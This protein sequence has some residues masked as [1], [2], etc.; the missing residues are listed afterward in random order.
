MT[1]W[2]ISFAGKS[3]KDFEDLDK[4]IKSRIRNVILEL[5]ELENPQT[6][7]KSKSLKYENHDEFSVRVGKHRFIYSL[8]DN[9]HFIVIK[10]IGKREK[11]YI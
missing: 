3:D 7:P 9:N 4:I 5:M 8:D 11:F 10:K 6:H 2:R 1:K